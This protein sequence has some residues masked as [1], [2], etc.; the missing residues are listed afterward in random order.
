MHY[1]LVILWLASCVSYSR[2]LV[3]PKQLQKGANGCLTPDG[4]ELKIGEFVQD[5]NVC[6]ALRCESLDGKANIM[7]CQVPVYYA[8]CRSSYIST[9]EPFPRCCWTCVIVIDC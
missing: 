4:K 6:G 9:I 5:D 2:T 1:W 8:Q 7:Y 3:F